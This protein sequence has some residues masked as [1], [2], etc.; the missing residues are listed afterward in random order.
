MV[1]IIS[2]DGYWIDMVIRSNHFAAHIDWQ[3]DTKIFKSLVNKKTIGLLPQ[4]NGKKKGARSAGET[5]K[6][7]K[8]CYGVSR[9]T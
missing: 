7:K 3:M 1:S 9:D 8:N 5:I 6:F 2:P 4:K